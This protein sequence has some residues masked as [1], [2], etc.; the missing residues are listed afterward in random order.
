MI[1]ACTMHAHTHVYTYVQ[2]CV[3]ADVYVCE[4]RTGRIRPCVCG[5]TWL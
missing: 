4:V 2:A 3:H 5:D 1:R